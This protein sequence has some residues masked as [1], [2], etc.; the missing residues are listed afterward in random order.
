MN[1]KDPA[2]APE[3]PLIEIHSCKQTII[4]RS[5]HT[6]CDRPTDEAQEQEV[7]SN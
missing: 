6:P 3:E 2:Y 7:N 5:E 1:K 4:I